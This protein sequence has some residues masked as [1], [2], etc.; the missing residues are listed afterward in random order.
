MD[1]KLI[2]L[3]QKR[4]LQRIQRALPV[5][6]SIP[7]HLLEKL[8]QSAQSIV[9]VLH[10]IIEEKRIEKEDKADGEIWLTSAEVAKQINIHVKTVGRYCREKK[11]KAKKVGKGWLINKRDLEKF[12]KDDLS[13]KQL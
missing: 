3:S 4:L 6:R 10:Q 13:D 7:I 2:Y 11:I 5:T 8:E 12:L 9:D 1:K